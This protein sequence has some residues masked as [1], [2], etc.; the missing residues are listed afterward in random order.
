MAR[1]LV[2]SVEYQDYRELHVDSLVGLDDITAKSG[3]ENS[4][5]ATVTYALSLFTLNV[6]DNTYYTAYTASN[7]IKINILVT[8]DISD[9]PTVTYSDVTIQANK[10]TR[11]R[12]NSLTAITHNSTGTLVVN[13]IKL[14]NF[15]KQNSGTDYI[16]FTG[17][18]S[19][20][21][22]HNIQTGQNVSWVTF[23]YLGF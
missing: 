17:Y 10:A 5:F 23:E 1:T 21:S 20:T 19:S 9:S 14:T 8:G 7:A 12:H 18:S 11:N 15:T 6:A 13:G 4:R 3:D 2:D 16:N 22:T